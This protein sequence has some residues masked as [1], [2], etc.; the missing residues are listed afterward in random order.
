LAAN[1]PQAALDCLKPIRECCF[2]ATVPQE[3][4][5]AAKQDYPGPEPI[6]TFLHAGHTIVGLV[7]AECQQG[8]IYISKLVLSPS[9]R[10]GGLGRMLVS[11]ALRQSQE[12]GAT[13]AHVRTLDFQAPLYY[14]RLGFDMDLTRSVSGAW[15]HERAY[16]CFSAVVPPLDTGTLSGLTDP[17]P[18]SKINGA[19]VSITAVPGDRTDYSDA[20]FGAHTL[21]TVGRPHPSFPRRTVYEALDR[22]GVQVG[23]IETSIIWD[24]MWVKLLAVVP[25]SR[26]KGIGKALLNAAVARAQALGSA[27]A[28]VVTTDVE[29]RSFFVHAGWQVDVERPPLTWLSLQI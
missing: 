23:A 13:V 25:S 6:P 16:Y 3:Q 19:D 7:L 2:I 4:F 17:Q 21:A 27:L 28:A 5:E 9:F 29:S 22:N 14:G 12:W 20:T 10:R 8:C 18:L 24:A 15:V 11:F 1:V 26:R